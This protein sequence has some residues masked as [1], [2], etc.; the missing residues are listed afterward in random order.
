MN[1]RPILLI[2]GLNFFTRHFVVNPSMSE[3]GNHIGG[4]VGFLKG[5]R[6]SGGSR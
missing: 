6:L 2:D 1:D 5:I 3:T 4:M